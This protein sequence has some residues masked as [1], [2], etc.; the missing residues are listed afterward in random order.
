[1][2]SCVLPI[3]THC[4]IL[5]VILLF[6]FLTDAGFRSVERKSQSNNSPNTSLVFSPSAFSSHSS[7]TSTSTP[8]GS[9]RYSHGGSP[10]FTP[11]SRTPSPPHFRPSPDSHSLGNS[12]SFLHSSSSFVSL[13]QS[14]NVSRS[15]SFSRVSIPPVG[16][17]FLLSPP[18]AFHP[19]S[20]NKLNVRH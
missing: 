19:T 2:K 15:A 8:L 1:M 11:P 5:L 18:M 6:D 17:F 10:C 7:L 12:G 4:M 14:A 16:H 20:Q 9:P 13:N 3:N